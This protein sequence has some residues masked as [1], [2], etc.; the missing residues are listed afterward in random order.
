MGIQKLRGGPGPPGPSPWLRHWFN[1]IMLYTINTIQ[2]RLLSSFPIWKIKSMFIRY[3]WTYGLFILLLIF[4]FGYQLYYN[5]PTACDYN[6]RNTINQTEFHSR[7]KSR[8]NQRLFRLGQRFSHI[9][10][11]LLFSIQTSLLLKQ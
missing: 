3:Y 2:Y 5:Y 1:S 10:I 6:H 4:V 11:D 7:F 8:L 9:D